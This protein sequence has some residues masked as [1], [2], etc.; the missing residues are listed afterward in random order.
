[1]PEYLTTPQA[2]KALGVSERSLRRWV[3]DGL[4][5]PDYVTPGGHYRWDVDRVRTELREEL[6]RRRLE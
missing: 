3:L 4:L 1:V 6:R 2:A 5:E